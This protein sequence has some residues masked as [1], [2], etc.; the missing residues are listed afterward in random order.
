MKLIEREPVRLSLRAAAVGCLV[1]IAILSLTPPA[2]LV[3]T[4]LGGHAEHVFAYLVCAWLCLVTFKPW[5]FRVL[6][7]GLLLPYAG[8]LEFLQSMVPG[9]HSAFN[10]FIFSAGG[11]MVGAIASL[12]MPVRA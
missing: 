2:H 5:R 9:R 7:F 3:R 10:D 8:L 1:A 11:V 4:S 6:I 12:L